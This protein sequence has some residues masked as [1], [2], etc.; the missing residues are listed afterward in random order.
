VDFSYPS[1]YGIIHSDWAVHGATATWHVTIPAN[2]TGWLSDD[3]AAGWT[4]V[5]VERHEGIETTTGP[6]GKHGMRLAAGSY[7]F[8]A[9]GKQTN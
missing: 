7:D 2:A 1:P 5:P 3:A 4:I 9:T 6:T 8:K